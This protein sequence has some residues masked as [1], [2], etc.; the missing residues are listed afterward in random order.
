LRT[1]AEYL[2]QARAFDAL[3]A[4]A[5]VESLQKRYAD[6]AACYRL[7]AE[8]R[9]RLIAAG[10]IPRDLQAQPGTSS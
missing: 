10:D 1:V 4:A 7:L 5:P 6:L 2:D 8:E 9:K 3:A